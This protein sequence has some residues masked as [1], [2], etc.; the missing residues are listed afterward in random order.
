M[1]SLRTISRV[2]GRVLFFLTFFIVL[3]TVF[4]FAQSEEESFRADVEKVYIL[5]KD[6]PSDQV[7]DI[8]DNLNGLLIE[9]DAIKE[10]ATGSQWAAWS[11]EARGYILQAEELRRSESSEDSMHFIVV[12]AQLMVIVFFSYIVLKFFPRVFW[13]QWLRFKGDWRIEYED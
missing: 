7:S 5:I 3:T 13:G 1:L 4:S 10:T 11:E 6:L 8:V 2:L 9:V 12:V